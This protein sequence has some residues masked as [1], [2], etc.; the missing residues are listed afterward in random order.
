MAF[1]GE[2]SDSYSALQHNPEKTITQLIISRLRIL[3]R[4][5]QTDL[6]R[7]AKETVEGVKKI[8]A[9]IE[10]TIGP[11]SIIGHGETR[12]GALPTIGHPDYVAKT[13]VASMISSMLRTG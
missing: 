3:D 9:E 4:T 6:E 5:I 1:A 10:T 11:L 8:R 2:T 13:E 12:Y 7:W